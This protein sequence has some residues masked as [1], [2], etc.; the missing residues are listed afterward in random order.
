MRRP[1]SRPKRHVVIALGCIGL[2]ATALLVDYYAFPYGAS[3]PTHSADKGTNGLWVRYTYYFG[4]K[5]DAQVQRLCQRLRESGIRDAFFHVRSIQA[6]GTLKFRYPDNARKLVA[7][8]HTQAPGARALAWIYA[9]NARGQGSVKLRDPVAR[10]KMV[11]EA[12]WLCTVCGFEGVQWDYEICEDG[13]KDLLALLSETRAALPQGKI[14]SVAAPMWFPAV[15]AFGWSEDYFSQVAARSDQVCVMCYDTGMLLPRAYVA[16]TA[17]NVAHVTH[18]V[19]Q[20]NPQCGVLLG[21]PTYGKGLFSH[22]PRAENIGNALLGVH[23]GLADPLAQPTA[24]L[25]IALFADYTTDEAEWKV[26]QRQWESTRDL[27]GGYPD[28]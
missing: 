21:I 19:A 12:V 20:G 3:P 9:G 18:A 4:E 1:L 14:L 7:A 27:T 15:R 25:G 5:S 11:A 17:Q 23:A 28:R 26:Y 6:D 2:L 10:R 24:F 16:L 8:M 13:D 22:N